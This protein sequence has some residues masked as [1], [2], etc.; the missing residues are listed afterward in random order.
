M[1]YLYGL[2]A[3]F[4]INFI[5]ALFFC[6]GALGSGV[7]CQAGIWSPVLQLVQELFEIGLLFFFA[8]LI[9]I[10]GFVLAAFIDIDRART[11]FRRDK[12]TGSQARFLE[13]YPHVRYAYGFLFL[14]IIFGAL[15]VWAFHID[16]KHQ[17][18]RVQ[19]INQ[20]NELLK[21]EREKL[22]NP[23]QEASSEVLSEK[24]MYVAPEPG[25]LEWINQVE[26][27]FIEY[28]IE[29]NVL[30]L[31]D[32]IGRF[33]E[34]YGRLPEKSTE[35]TDFVPSLKPRYKNE[36]EKMLGTG[37]I[38]QVFYQKLTEKQYTLCVESEKRP[39]HIDEFGVWQQKPPLL[40]VER[41]I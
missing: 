30:V 15:G 4:E 20:R 24:S 25:S 11:G 26:G 19:E 17:R 34:K 23:A 27:R 29:N 10:G 32:V 31:N 36:T 22:M 28:D 16:S 1:K 3:F 18:D 2:I 41:G 21:Q 13:Q 39:Q 35:F 6:R 5:A 14:Q 9:L 37:W 8:P 33:F 7:H 12:A 40:C 38:Y